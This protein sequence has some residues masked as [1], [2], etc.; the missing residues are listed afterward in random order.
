MS[1]LQIP[2]QFD[3][4]KSKEESEI[5]SLRKAV[6]AAVESSHKVRKKLFGENGKLVKRMN[7]LEERLDILERNICKGVG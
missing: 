5:E 4:F 6:D 7:E 2:I 1:A 3:L